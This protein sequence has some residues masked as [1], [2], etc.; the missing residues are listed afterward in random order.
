MIYHE[1]KIGTVLFFENAHYFNTAVKT[2]ENEW[3]IGGK[4]APH[5]DAKLA[6]GIL[7]AGHVVTVLR[8]VQ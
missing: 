4:A 5:T 3:A 7:A 8:Q 6:R 1:M 2:G